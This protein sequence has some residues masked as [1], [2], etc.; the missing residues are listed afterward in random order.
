MGLSS[1][2]QAFLHLTPSIPCF[3]PFFFPPFSFPSFFLPPPSFPSLLSFLPPPL[4]SFLS[5]SLLPPSL[6]LSFLPLSFLPSTSLSLLPS[7]HPSLSF[8]PPS[9]LLPHQPQ[10]LGCPTSC[11]EGC[12]D[13]QKQ[14]QVCSVASV[15]S[16]LAPAVAAPSFSST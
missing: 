14:L 1:L 6:H 3:S 15:C 11:L 12:T 13:L 4:P 10:L 2:H 8:P 7:S 5:L 9:L 16:F